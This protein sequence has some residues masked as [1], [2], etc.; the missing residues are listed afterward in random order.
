MLISEWNAL[1]TGDHVLVHDPRIVEMTL[2]DGTV[3]TIETNRGA[4]GVGI[5]L[6]GHSGE[7]AVLWPSRLVMHR[8]PLDPT[9][10]CWRCEEM[11]E[12]TPPQADELPLAQGRREPE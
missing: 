10:G 9:E 8:E 4:N 3:T 11:A 2:T 12:R 5:R 6:E 7:S 1:R